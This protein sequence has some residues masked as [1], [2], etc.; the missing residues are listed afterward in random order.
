MNSGS[1]KLVVFGVVLAAFGVLI[2]VENVMDGFELQEAIGRH[3]LHLLLLGGL[4]LFCFLISA[5][6]YKKE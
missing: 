5:I 6:L 4:S 2:I 1:K 3:L